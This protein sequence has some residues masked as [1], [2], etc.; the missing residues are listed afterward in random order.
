VTPV[1]PLVT[2]DGDRQTIAATIANL[3]HNAFK[4]TRKNGSVALTTRAT[5][6]LVSFDIEDG[7]GGLP[8][9]KV[10]DLFRP[11]EQR[12]ADRSGV[13]LGLSICL[14]AAKANG[15]EIRVRDIPGKGCVFTLDLPRRPP[16]P[17]SVVDGKKTDE[18]KGKAGSPGRPADRKPRSGR[19]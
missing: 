4:F 12:G 6:D 15:G 7:C 1:A 3:L 11:F 16:P 2:I 8:P 13:G 10:E 5:A 19:S 17:L 18:K 9:G 14:K